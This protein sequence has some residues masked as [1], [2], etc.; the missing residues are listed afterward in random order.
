MEM[1]T[2]Q[3]T[4]MTY[5]ELGQKVKEVFLP[6]G[7]FSMHFEKY[8]FRKDQM[9]MALI[10]AKSIT[11]NRPAIIEAGTG[12]GK[13]FG[14]L[15]PAALYSTLAGKRILV[16]THTIALQQQLYAK[17]VPT[18]QDVLGL[19]GLEFSSVLLKGKGNFVCLKQLGEVI[20]ADNPADRE[21]L[22][23]F[24]NVAVQD[25][26]VIVGDKEKLPYQPEDDFWGKISPNQNTVC[27][28]CPFY[29]DGCF[30][31]HNKEKAKTADIIISNHYMLIA[32]L[33]KRRQNNY[34]PNSGLLPDYDVVIVDEAH[35]LEDVASEMLGL[36]FDI[37]GI[38]RTTNRIKRAFNKGAMKNHRED[39]KKE[40]I[41]LCDKI[42]SDF[43]ELFQEVLE[44]LNEKRMGATFWERHLD[45]GYLELLQK[46]EQMLMY[47][48]VRLERDQR[49]EQKA[50]QGLVQSAE[51]LRAEVES[52]SQLE[53]EQENIYWVSRQKDFFKNQTSGFRVTPLEINKYLKEGLFD[54]LP[55]ILCSATIKF[56][57]DL[58][59]FAKKIGNLEPGTYESL[60]VNAPFD[61]KN[62]VMFYVP[63]HALDVAK[64]S[65]E[66]GKQMYDEYCLEEME[67]LVKISK[68]RAFLLF[69]NYT[70]MRRYHEVLAPIFEEWGYKCFK[71]GDMDKGQ[72]IEQFTNHGNAVLFG[73]DSFWEG[74][75]IDGRE[76][77]LV[78]IHK[79]PF[80]VPNPVTQA[81]QVVIKKNG[82]DPFL[83]GH[84][85]SAVTKYKQGFGR[86]IRHEDDMGVFCVLDARII[87]QREKYGKYFLR[88]TP[89]TQKSIYREDLRPFLD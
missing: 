15:V 48:Q 75:S 53:D 56:D 43:D 61:Y 22:Q 44:E 40:I 52:I 78:I 49:D 47:I 31:R 83:E 21:H 76:L 28:G 73:A 3:D 20:Q 79:L 77:S 50:M 10:I 58:S 2:K 9:Q 16:V 5:E 72:M 60:T 7:Y 87:S 41:A 67:E 69:T 84:V 13:S 46:L 74:I 26:E 66:E 14:E 36:H 8:A 81:R 33:D 38:R 37:D 62:K 19:A 64:S 39:Q 24:L 80:A 68:G 29:E 25:D 86:L 57:K 35:H 71:Q 63:D 45:N 51:K 17:D 12:T 88:S 32:D 42:I 82:G 6:G 65:D 18:V 11:E 59:F 1:T 89:D 70:D 27:E 4:G 34:K 55:T 54:R 85:F 23:K 30:M